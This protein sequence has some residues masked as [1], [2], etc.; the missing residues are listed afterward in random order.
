MLALPISPLLLQGMA[1]LFSTSRDTHP[2]SNFLSQQEHQAVSWASHKLVC[3]ASQCLKDFTAKDWTSY[4]QP[5]A[6]P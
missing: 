1:S 3:S 2:S 5:F 4:S 6:F